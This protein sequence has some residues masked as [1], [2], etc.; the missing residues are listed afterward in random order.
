MSVPKT[1]GACGLILLLA[2]AGA[3]ANVVRIEIAQDRAG[4][5]LSREDFRQGL[6]RARS[7]RSQ[8]RRH[9]R[10]RAGA[11]QRARQGRVRR[12]VLAREADRHVDGER[13][14]ALH[15]REPRRRQR[16]RQCRRACHARQRLAGRRRPDGREPDDSR[17]G[18]EKPRRHRAL[19]VRSS[20]ASR[21]SPV[22]RRPLM[23]PRNQPSPYPPASLDTTKATLISATAESPTGVKSGIGD[24]SEH[25]LGVCRL[26][27]DPVSRQTGSGAHLSE[28]RVQPRAAVRAALHREGSA[29]ARHR[30]RRH[31]RSRV[32]LQVRETGRDGRRQIPSPAASRTRYRGRQLAVGHVPA[33]CRCCSAST[34]TSAGRIVWDGMNPHI[35][36]AVHG[37]ESPVRISRRPRVAVRAWARRTGVV[38]AVGRHRAQPSAREP[39]RSLP[40][41]A[42]PVRRSSRRS[43][44]PRSGACGSRSRSSGRRRRPTFPCRR[45]CGATTSQA[46]RTAAGPAGSPPST[47]SRRPC[48]ACALPTNPAPVGPMRAALMKRSDGV[49]D[50]KA[51]RCRPSKYPKLADGTLVQNTTGGDGISLDSR[52][53]VARG[54]SASAHRLRSWTAVPLHRSVGRA[55]EDPGRQGHAASARRPSGRRRQRSGRNSFAAAGGTA[56]HLHRVERHDVR[57]LQGTALH[58]SSVARRSAASSPSR[59]RKPS[60]WRAAIRG[61]RSKSVI[62]IT[63]AT[64]APSRRRP[65][66]SCAR[67]TCCRTMPRQSCRRHRA[68]TSSGNHIGDW[69]IGDWA[70]GRTIHGAK[71]G[72]G[73]HAMCSRRVAH[74]LARHSG[75]HHRSEWPSAAPRGC[76][77]TN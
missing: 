68:A 7:R 22:T 67:D 39:A 28:G 24:D 52:H 72:A 23:I 4:G 36:G 57:R 16:R 44:R 34:R 75:R 74:V 71:S 43:A 5:A 62:A 33:S 20:C 61:C 40:R 13:R 51:R 69:V 37:S 66:R 46:S 53:A 6:R 14:A 70:M 56:R 60:A 29:R 47:E 50:D 30:P 77:R 45:T 35:A 26:L 64:C 1:F 73:G 59:R 10:H 54:P 65:T 27:D 8:E 18:R 63:T 15:R 55:D 17:P 41:H 42:T 49:G 31:P 25:R 38:D 19:P 3:H 32:V 58:S 76:C 9:H 21:T 2:T 11:A 12:D 48:A